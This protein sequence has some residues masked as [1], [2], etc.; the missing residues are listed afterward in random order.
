MFPSPKSII[1]V[2]HNSKPFIRI[3]FLQENHRLWRWSPEKW[4]L[5]H[6]V[7]LTQF[8]KVL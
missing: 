7:F 4:Y 1:V 3:Y 6:F 5:K 8:R 2:P